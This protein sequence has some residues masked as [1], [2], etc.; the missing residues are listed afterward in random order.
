M[1]TQ[2]RER[3]ESRVMLPLCGSPGHPVYGGHVCCSHTF[4]AAQLRSFE[5]LGETGYSSRLTFL[6]SS[7]GQA[8]SGAESALPTTLRLHSP[9]GLGVPMSWNTSE[10]LEVHYLLMET[11]CMLGEFYNCPGQLERDPENPSYL[12]SKH[13]H[14][15]LRRIKK[16]YRQNKI[17]SL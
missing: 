16:S 3:T 15:N 17:I 8:P 11:W 10:N 1:G 13:D 9:A 7:W 6:W 5:S 4:H 12:P 2:G 14:R